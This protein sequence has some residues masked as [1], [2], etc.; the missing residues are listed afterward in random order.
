MPISLL[1]R[2]TYTD[3][4]NYTFIGWF[5][6]GFLFW[7]AIAENQQERFMIQVTPAVYFLTVLAIQSIWNGGRL[8]SVSDV[9][10][11]LEGLATMAYELSKQGYA[12]L[13]RGYLI[14]RKWLSLFPIRFYLCAF[15]ISYLSLRLSTRSYSH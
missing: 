7:S 4:Y 12:I 5:L 11:F 13:K 10:D 6:V 15:L 3:K 14:S 1:F 2:R 8:L 9:R